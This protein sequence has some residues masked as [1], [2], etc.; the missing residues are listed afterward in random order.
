MERNIHVENFYNKMGHNDYFIFK[1]AM[2][3]MGLPNWL[4]W[5]AWFVKTF[6]MM[7]ISVVLLVVLMSL[8]CYQ[9]PDITIFTHADWSLLLF[10]LLFYVCATTAFTFAVSAF[11]STGK[12]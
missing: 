4:N 3:I 10:F 1:E 8:K 7:T 6:G 2:Q 11:F 5:I 9:N 12:Y